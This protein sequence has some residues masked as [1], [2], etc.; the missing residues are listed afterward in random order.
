MLFHRERGTPVGGRTAVALQLRTKASLQSDLVQRLGRPIGD[1]P[2]QPLE[3]L[4][5]TRFC[6]PSIS[7]ALRVCALVSSRLLRI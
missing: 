4:A 5:G 7:C 2:F 3:R 1:Y 6:T